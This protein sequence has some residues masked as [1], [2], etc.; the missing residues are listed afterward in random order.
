[1]AYGHLAPCLT[2]AAGVHYAKVD[3]GRRRARTHKGRP[4]SPRERTGVSR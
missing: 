1:M 3:A 2:V 4:S